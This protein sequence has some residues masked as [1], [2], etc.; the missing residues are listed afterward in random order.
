MVFSKDIIRREF[1]EHLALKADANTVV[2]KLSDLVSFKFILFSA[3]SITMN[4][5][6]TCLDRILPAFPS[7]ISTVI[8]H[9]SIS[10]CCRH[11]ITVVIFNRLP[12][13]N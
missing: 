3:L 11:W 8:L 4:P 1:L 9:V 2:C 10:S 7:L 5:F 12:D 13:S 6:H